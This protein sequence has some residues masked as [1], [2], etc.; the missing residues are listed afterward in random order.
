MA[1][2]LVGYLQR[3]AEETEQE[4]LRIAEKIEADARAHTLLVEDV[5]EAI[6]DDLTAQE[7]CANYAAVVEDERQRQVRLALANEVGADLIEQELHDAR[8]AVGRS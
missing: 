6:A 3:K 2:N 1:V 7:V 5:F 4:M 8:V